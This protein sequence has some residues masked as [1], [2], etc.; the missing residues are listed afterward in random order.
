MEH[1]GVKTS[2]YILLISQSDTYCRLYM[3][4]Q[5]NDS[6]CDS[7]AALIRL[8]SEYANQNTIKSMRVSFGTL[9]LSLANQTTCNATT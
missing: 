6:F 4:R 9:E 2:L 5:V 8:I 1:S 7:V 3:L